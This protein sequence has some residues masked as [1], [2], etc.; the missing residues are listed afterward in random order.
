MQKTSSI[1]KLIEQ[2]EPNKRPI[3]R[4]IVTELNFMRRTL[5][6]LRKEIAENGTTELFQN[7]KQT[8]MRKTP[9]FDAYTTLIARYGTLNKQLTALLPEKEPEQGDELDEFLGEV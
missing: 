6:K 7:G 2:V 3:A 8:M 4:H 1:S 5:A 9:A